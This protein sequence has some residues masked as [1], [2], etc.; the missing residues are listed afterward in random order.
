MRLWLWLIS[1]TIAA[2]QEPTITPPG[3]C[4][5]SPPAKKRTSR[6]A[7]LLKG[8]SPTPS[9]LSAKNQS[10]VAASAALTAREIL[11]LSSIATLM[12][13]PSSLDPWA[14]GMVQLSEGENASTC[15]GFE[16]LLCED[17]L[18]HSDPNGTQLRSSPFCLLRSRSELV[19]AW[20]GV[21]SLEDAQTDGYG[22]AAPAAVASAVSDDAS[23]MP[24]VHGGFADAYFAS[25]AAWRVRYLLNMSDLDA[26]S[27]ADLQARLRAA[28]INKI[29]VGAEVGA[30]SLWSKQRVDPQFSGAAL[31][32]GTS[33]N[34]GLPPNVAVPNISAPS[35]PP[36][37]P[38]LP[39]LSS[40]PLP[41]R[42]VGHAMGGAIGTLAANDVGVLIRKG[43]LPER[44]IDLVSLGKPLIILYGFTARLFI[45]LKP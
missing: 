45:D 13:Q 2:G 11:V 10:A 17:Q 25:G 6:N 34:L 41:L 7:L 18:L 3:N 14:S 26:A 24:Q 31:Q 42:I 43:A 22:Y 29:K 8:A 1:L 44:S 16:V 39:V 35:P 32:A 40:P 23:M 20:R 36:T 12:Y 15:V 21:L 38:P 28:A 30:E 27:P 5:A 33:A 19:L 9:V 4:S 37:P